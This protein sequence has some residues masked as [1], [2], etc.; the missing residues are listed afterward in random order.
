MVRSAN[1]GYCTSL[2]GGN[3]TSGDPGGGSVRLGT[4][5]VRTRGASAGEVVVVDHREVCDLGGVE[6]RWVAVARPRFVD[7]GVEASVDVKSGLAAPAA[8]GL[9]LRPHR[10]TEAAMRTLPRTN[11]LW[12]VP[13]HSEGQGSFAPRSC[14]CVR[15][16][17]SSK[18]ED[19]I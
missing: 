15:G 13:R 10:Q 4:E 19:R 17:C 16:N 9:T 14:L 18:S 3:S 1:C 12:R 6:V 8:E 11:Q 7:G 2:C 5:I